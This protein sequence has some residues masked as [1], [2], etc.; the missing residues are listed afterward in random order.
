MT[1]PQ[2]KG[3]SIV[4]DTHEHPF[5]RKTEQDFEVATSMEKLGK[6]RA[7]F[8]KG[9]TVTAGNSSVLNDGACAL[10]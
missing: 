1:I 5:Y 9:G 6:L 3:D 7:V 10:Y 4:V 2:R 8:R